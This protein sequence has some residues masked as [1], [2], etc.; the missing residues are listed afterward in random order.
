MSGPQE[1]GVDRPEPLLCRFYTHGRRHPIVIGNI[2]GLRIP[3]VTPAQL[4]IGVGTLVLL[5]MT[6]ALWAHFGA[7]A[8]GFVLVALPVGLAWAARAVRMEG[9]APWRAGL[10]WLQLVAGPREGVCLGRRDRPMRPARYRGPA[11]IV[12][13]DGDRPTTR[14]MAPTTIRTRPGT[15]Q[16]SAAP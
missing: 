2:Q 10:G 5:A 4:G 1:W 8:N 9:R 14:R 15:T 7:A 6:R 12:G 11:W 3:P 16:R 13:L